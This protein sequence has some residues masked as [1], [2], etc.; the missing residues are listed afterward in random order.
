MQ[1][2]LAWP[3]ESAARSHGARTA[4]IDGGRHLTYRELHH[5]VRRIGAGLAD[6]GIEPGGVVAVLMANSLE[7]VESWLAVPAYGRVLTSLNTRLAVPDLA[8]MLEDS[9]A[10]LLIVDAVN[11]E[12]GR[13]LRDL[14]PGLKQV[15]FAGEGA[16][17]D[18]CLPYESLMADEGVAPPDLDP[19]SLAVVMYT[20][21]TTGRPKGV[22]L[23]HA[24]IL[25]NCKHNFHQDE[26]RR[27]DVVVHAPPFFHAAGAQ[28]IHSVTWVGGT[29]V[30]LPR[31]TPADY[32]KAVAEH[33]GTVAFL[34]PTMIHML[35]DHLEEHPAD[36][37]SLRLLH[38]GSSP[39]SE[40]LLR[41]TA[42]ALGCEFVQGYGMTEMSPGCTFLS[43]E[44][45]RKALAGEAVQRLKSVG[46]PLPG[47]QLEIRDGDG[48][49]VADGTVGEV[50]VRGPNIM[51]GYLNR[52]EETSQAL[53]D[54]WY[55][56][57][58][59]GYYD[60]DGYVF[61]VDRIKD[62][63]ITGGEN[64]YSLEVER[65]LE[66]HP[67]VVEAAVVGVPDDR[68][69]ERVHAVVVTDAGSAVTEGDLIEHCRQA[70]ARYKVPKTVEVRSGPLPRSA[71]GKILK[72]EVRGKSA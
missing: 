28:M 50:W 17:P 38:F 33:R 63:I 3:L 9:G 66:T 20:G 60:E 71:S 31:F 57:G 22:M 2:T 27:D 21:G 1:G 8:Y 23:S 54:G 49:P 37:S 55:R 52:P 12:A 51:L 39:M 36:L 70:L 35:L 11:L 19:D 5:R 68:W 45:H 7:H 72:H 13:S 34:V 47:V 64:V 48:R 29:H 18:D 42:K 69:G 61:L 58:D 67:E 10:E 46:Y 41:R 14:V 56:T 15:L 44:D 6:S 40:K 30:L 43:Q 62:M 4:V 26:F 53:V 65:V 16:C 59:G 24:G 25:D 32:A